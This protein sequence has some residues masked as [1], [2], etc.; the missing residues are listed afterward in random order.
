MG[1]GTRHC[2][3]LTVSNINSDATGVDMTSAL[4]SV[5]L[6]LKKSESPFQSFRRDLALNLSRRCDLMGWDLALYHPD[7]ERN[8]LI[9]HQQKSDIP[10]FIN[11]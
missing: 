10:S 6:R 7:A 11:L 5:H 8:S 2:R 4:I 9:I 3:V 1:V